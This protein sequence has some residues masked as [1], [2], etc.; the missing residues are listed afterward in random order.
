MRRQPFPAIGGGPS[1]KPGSFSERTIGASVQISMA[2]TG[3]DHVHR[4][5]RSM[6]A[7]EKRY[8]KLFAERHMVSGH[9][10]QSVLFDA[11]AAMPGYDEEALRRRFAGAAFLRR[12]AV[13][14]HRLY[15]TVLASLEAF[16]ADGTV[17]A[18]IRRYLNRMELLHQ[19]GLHAD[20]DRLLGTVRGLAEQSGRAAQRLEVLEWE[21]RS[22]ERDNYQGVQEVDIGRWSREMIA[23]LGSFEREGTLWALKSQA[24]MLLYHQGKARSEADAD[25]LRSLLEHPALRPGTMP[26]EARARFQW[27]HVRSALFFGLNELAACEQELSAN[28]AL[29]DEERACFQEDVHL[30]LG[31][32]SNLAYV[33]MR[34]GRYEEALA[35]SK[36]F[37]LLPAMLPQAPH[38]DLEVRVFGM[39]VSLELAILNRMG[40]FEKAMERLEEV[41]VRLGELEGRLSAIR[42]AGIRFQAAWSC[43]GAE[44]PAQALRW[45]RELLNERGMEAHPEIHALGRVLLLLLLLETGKGDVL[46]Y[47]LRN[48]E[49]HLRSHGREHGV[50]HALLGFIRRCLKAGGRV[51][52]AAAADLQ[53]QLAALA[54]DPME[55]GA[56]D[57]FDP[58]CYAISRASGTSMA[59]VAQARAR[60]PEGAQGRHAA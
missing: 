21:R 18:R 40:R 9:N 16:H 36:R 49:R 32:M 54:G 57:H 20:A 56:F 45:C 42:K 4:L 29:M 33:R 22:M 30:R 13:T 48:V 41:T 37:K 23:V 31:V 44:Q 60:M 2:S 52:P 5:I 26:G 34:L 47:E 53:E 43:L 25:A 24:F 11:I 50:E 6:S 58:C 10:N 35:G 51:L 14:K 27:H 15:D 8:F 1:D 46:R 55:Q 39:G 19:R 59:Q 12:F 28:E 38:A 3:T 17:E 7:A